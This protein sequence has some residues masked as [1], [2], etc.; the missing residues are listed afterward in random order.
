MMTKSEIIKKLPMVCTVLGIL[1]VPI[2]AYLSGKAAVKSEKDISDVIEDTGIDRDEV[3]K[4][5]ILR[6]TWKNYIPTAV[7][8]ALTIACILISYKLSKKEI[9]ALSAAAAYITHQKGQLED[10]IVEKYGQ[11]ALDD[12]RK[13]LAEEMYNP[14]SVEL[15]GNGDLLCYECYSGRWFRS[16]EAAIEKAESKFNSRFACGKGEYMNL[17]DLYRLFNIEDSNFGYE[18]GWPANTDYYDGPITFT[19]HLCAPGEFHDIPEPVLLIEFNNYD[20]PMNG[21]MEV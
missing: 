13:E 15:T 19:N 10:K 1:G 16:S 7:S 20:Y 4:G 2:T 9:M 18:M 6:L 21:W 11:K 12:I 5:D 14:Q 3:R 17:C 8:G